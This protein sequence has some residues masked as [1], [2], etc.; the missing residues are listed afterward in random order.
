MNLGG[1]I[2]EYNIGDKVAVKVTDADGNMLTIQTTV[3][4]NITKAGKVRVGLD[5]ML[6]SPDD[7]YTDKK[8]GN[9]FKLAEITDDGAILEQ[10]Q[11]FSE[12]KESLID[13]IRYIVGQCKDINVLRSVYNALCNDVYQNN[14]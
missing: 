3:V 10:P 4:T 14:N 11:D 2:M 9:V 7:G 12:E 6:L 13:G 1:K 8:T 5:N